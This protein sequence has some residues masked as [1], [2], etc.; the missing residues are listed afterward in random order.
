MGGTCSKQGEIKNQFKILVRKPEVTI[1]PRR[2]RDSIKWVFLECKLNL[3][4]SG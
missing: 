3:K 2:P 4:G 1:P